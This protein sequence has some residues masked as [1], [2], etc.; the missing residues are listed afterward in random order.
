MNQSKHNYQNYSTE[1]ADQGWVL[2]RSF[3]SPEAV[4]DIRQWLSKNTEKNSDT[5]G[6]EPQFDVGENGKEQVYRKLRRMYW[7]DPKFWQPVL[8]N[9]GF[10][11]LAKNLT[12][13]QAALVFHAAYLKSGKIGTQT[14]FHQDQALW[15]GLYTKAITLWMPVTSS[16]LENGC[17]QVCP[18]SHLRGIIPHKPQAGHPFHDGIDILEEALYP[19]SVEMEPGDLLILDRFTVHGSAANLSDEPRNAVVAVFADSDDKNFKAE[20]YVHANI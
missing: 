1:L 20:E 2:V 16:T 17:I 9:E 18:K 12:G 19:I 11:E 5:D 15:Y 4:E 6:F 8:E 7:N 3:A 10:F 13:E 14:A